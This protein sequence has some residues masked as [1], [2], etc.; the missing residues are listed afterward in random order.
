MNEEGGVKVISV[1]E[2]K[3][4][5]KKEGCGGLLNQFGADSTTMSVSL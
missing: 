3:K 2:R 4:E 5:R 1:C